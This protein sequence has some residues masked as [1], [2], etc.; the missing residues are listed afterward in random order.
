[1]LPEPPG[2]RF[3]VYMG[4]GGPGHLDPRRNDGRSEG[5]QGIQED[6]SWEQA[7]FRLF[8]A[9]LADEGAALL[10]GLPHASA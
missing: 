9:I 7:V 4:T 2:G 8:D 3:A 5:S 10:G 1:M 6:P